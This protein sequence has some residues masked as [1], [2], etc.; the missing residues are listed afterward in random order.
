MNKNSKITI[1]SL[2]TLGVLLGIGATGKALASQNNNR[3]GRGGQPPQFNG[4]KMAPP[5]GTPKFASGT[6]KFDRNDKQ[7]GEHSSTSTKKEQNGIAGIISTISGTSLT[8]NS[9]E[10]KTYNV[11]ASNSTFKNGKE[12]ASVSNLKSGDMV[13]VQGTIND[14]AITA[15]TVIKLDISSSTQSNREFGNRN[16]QDI[17]TTTVSNSDQGLHKGFINKTINKV[18]SFFKKL[19]GKK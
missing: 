17:S 12:D 2:I 3:E 16:G 14:S 11:D 1:F 5:S 10:N 18:T 4:E 9:H 13:I 6:P 19:F 15:S 7:P 8:V